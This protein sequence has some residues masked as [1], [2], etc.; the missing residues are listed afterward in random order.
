MQKYEKYM[1]AHIPG[2]SIYADRIFL[3]VD[4]GS[5]AGAA[6]IAVM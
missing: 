5:P 1:L 4:E 3:A 6:V 2:S